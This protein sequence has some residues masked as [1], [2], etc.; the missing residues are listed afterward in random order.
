MKLLILGATG[1]TGRSLLEQALAAGHEVTALARDPARL[2]VQHARLR[3]LP[4]DVQDREAV[5]A[6]IAGQD[7]VVSA[8]GPTRERP[9]GKEMLTTGAGNIL[10]GMQRHD[11]RRLVY[12]TGAGVPDP[13]DEPPGLPARVMVS[14]LKLMAGDVLRDS[15]QAVRQIRESDRDWTILRAPRLGDGPAQGAY[16]IGYHRPGFQPIARADVAAALLK[17]VTDDAYRRQAPVISH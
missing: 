1:R 8:L 10:A 7:A 3:V 11:V 9:S 5:A 17:Q 6:A 2:T 12:L 16:R 15:E 14:L 4:G 13:R